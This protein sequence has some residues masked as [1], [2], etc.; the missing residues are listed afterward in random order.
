VF[1]VLAV[2]IVIAAALAESAAAGRRNGCR[3][4]ELGDPGAL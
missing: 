4:R 3:G 2:I 1:A